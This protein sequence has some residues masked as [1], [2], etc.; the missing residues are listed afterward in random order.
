MTD[1]GGFAAGWYPNPDGSPGLRWYDG[2]RWTDDYH[3]EVGQP[4]AGGYEPQAFAGGYEPQAFAGAAPNYVGANSG[5]QAPPAKNAWGYF[6]SV[7]TERY[8]DFSGR[9]RRSEYWWFW[10]LN[11][12]AGLVLS[13]I[14]F[15]IAPE[16][17]ALIFVI[18]YLATLLPSLG[19]TVRRLHD[20]NKSGWTMLLA[21]IP[22]GGII[23]LIFMLVDGDM[24]PNR[25]GYPPK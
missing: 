25:Y 5:Y 22:F 9:A 17:G 19:V 7:I 24:G 13:L 18:W 12:V 23:L 11:T 14:G 10:L 20:T 8:A 3:Y 15:M 16:A 21:F 6:T 4:G 1:Q 2:E